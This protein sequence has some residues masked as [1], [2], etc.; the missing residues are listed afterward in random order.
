MEADNLFPDNVMRGPVLVKVVIAVVHIA[1]SGCVVEQRIHP[2]INHMTRVKIDR[3]TPFETCARDAKILKARLDEIIDH[4]ID[5]GCRF[6][7]GAA[8]QKVLNGLGILGKPEEIRLFF[9][10]MYRPS[11]VRAVAVYQLAFCPEAFAGSAIL[12]FIGT[13]INIAVVIHFPEDALNRSHMIIV[14]RAD[15]TIVRDVHEL[16]QIKDPALP[17]H[18]PVDKYLRSNAGFFGFFLNLLAVFIRSGQKHHIIAG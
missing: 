18:D 2:D 1:E 6:Q 15:K 10:I 14:G 9:R 11:A 4:F 16:P 12:P 5:A 13:F 7:E 17:R 3:D 8:F